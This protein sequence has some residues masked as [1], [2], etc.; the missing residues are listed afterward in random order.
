MNRGKAPKE[1]MDAEKRIEVLLEV[2]SEEIPAGMLPKAEGDLR[3]NL[4]KLLSAENLADGITIE[5]FSAPR[6]LTARV[7]GLKE[8]QADVV[9]EVTGPPK[10]VAYDSVGEPTRAAHSFAEKQGVALRDLYTVQ[11]P[12]GEYLAAKQVRRGRTADARTACRRR[13]WAGH[14]LAKS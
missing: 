10:S 3:T 9:S 4:E 11:T 13:G 8:K 12:K 1:Q 2:G 6:R 7:Q 14:R 5:T